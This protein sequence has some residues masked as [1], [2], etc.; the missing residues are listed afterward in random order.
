ME[1][2]LAN[3]TM[4]GWRSL[5]YRGNPMCILMIRSIEIYESKCRAYM[6]EYLAIE[7]VY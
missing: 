6:E 7:D 4:V 5:G 2:N 1:P 3:M